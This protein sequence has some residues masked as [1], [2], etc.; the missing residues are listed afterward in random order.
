MSVSKLHYLDVVDGK[1]CET[2]PAELEILFQAANISEQQNHLVVHFHGGLVSRADATGVAELLIPDYR[3]CGCY[4]V[5]FFWNSGVLEV[6]AGNLKEVGEEPVFQRLVRRLAQ[7]LAAKLSESSGERGLQLQVESLKDIPENGEPLLE[8]TRQRESATASSVGGLKQTQR[9][10][11]ER[12]LRQDRMI[13]EE[14]RAIAAGL[15][16]AKDIELE[17]TTRG[18]NSPSVRA[19]R[20]T[21]MSPA[22]LKRIAAESPEAGTRSAAMVMALAKYGVEIAA[23]VVG[24]YRQNRDHGLLATIVEEVARML[25]ADSIG[26]TV[27]QLMKRDTEDAFG[28]DPQMHGGTAFIAH[29]GNWWKPGRRVTLV[30]HSTGAIYIGH[31]LEHADASLPQDFRFDVVFLAPACTYEFMCRRLPLFNRRI[32]G[33]RM[34]ALA[35]ALEQGYWEVPV[36]YPASLLYLVSGLFE[37]S[38][39]DMPI[40]GMQRYFRASGPYD[41]PM[42]HDVVKWIDDRCVWSI[43]EGTLGLQSTACRHGGFCEDITTRASLCHILRSGL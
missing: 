22:V 18:K 11:I 9:D 31:L 28:G 6:L 25:Y 43:A 33:F 37:E 5:F 35:D 40:L 27:W 38:E 20:K 2:S 12:E 36:L 24:R 39:I 1:F 19:S 32:S 16:E 15:R 29:L 21:L 4:P 8:W 17:L 13:V 41:R 34:F 7:F 42:T 26:S 3:E 30:G 10:Q 14:S 23:A